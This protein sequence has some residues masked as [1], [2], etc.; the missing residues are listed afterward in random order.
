VRSHDPILSCHPEQVPARRDESKDLH[1]L[2]SFGPSKSNRNLL[3]YSPFL[4]LFHPWE[5]G[6]HNRKTNSAAKPRSKS[7]TRL[8]PLIPRNRHPDKDPHKPAFRD[9]SVT[10]QRV[11]EAY[12]TVNAIVSVAIVLLLFEVAVT[13]TV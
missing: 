9:L 12:C 11:K 8:Q 13:V 7:Q 3:F 10:N 4:K 1:L 6:R 5:P 2:L